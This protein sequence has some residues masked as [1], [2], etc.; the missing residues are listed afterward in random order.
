[1]VRRERSVER[2][3][4]AERARNHQPCFFGLGVIS[5]AALEGGDEED[6]A[7]LEF[8]VF[9]ES[10]SGEKRPVVGMEAGILVQGS[11]GA[12]VEER[13]YRMNGSRKRWVGVS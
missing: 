13:D 2:I 1:M 10:A 11:T 5:A 3:T 8:D 12:V 9:V 6:L 4:L 7:C